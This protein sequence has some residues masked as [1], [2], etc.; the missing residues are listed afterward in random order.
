MTEAERN[1]AYEFDM[2]GGKPFQYNRPQDKI[3]RK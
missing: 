2:R 3:K 1:A